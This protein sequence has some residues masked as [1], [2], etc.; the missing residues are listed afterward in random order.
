MKSWR[1]NRWRHWLGE[2]LLSRLTV[3]ILLATIVSWLVFSVVLLYEA[4]KET[5]ELLDKQLSAYTQMLWQNL[6]DE[7]DLSAAPVEKDHH[8]VRLAFTLY[9]SDGSLQASNLLPSFPRQA[10]NAPDLR[11]INL[12]GQDWRICIRQNKDRQLIVGE[13]LG[14]HRKIAN[15]M[16]EHLLETAMLALLVLLPLLL[17]A[18]HRGLKPLQI[19]DRELAKRA[20]NNLEPLDLNV[21]SEIAPLRDRLNT[22]FEQVE[23]TLAR[24]RR[25]TADAAHELRTPLAGLR[26]QLE[27]AQSS[28]RTETRQK[29]LGRAIEGVDRT[30]HLVAQLLEMS[31]LE[32]GEAPTFS[33]IHLPDLAGQALRE[34]GIAC[35][36]PRLNVSD[37]IPIVGHALLLNL[38][39]RN[40]LDNAR[41]YA[42]S[43]AVVG[44]EIKGTQ[45]TVFDHG[46]G[47]SE[48]TLA[49]MGERFFR[50]AGQSQPGAGLGL[51]IV[52]RIA[53]L[54]GAELHFANR[55]E[56]GFLVG[57]QFKA[58][59]GKVL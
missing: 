2:S 35:E 45:L 28:P 58:I 8:H 19:V 26:V 37:P 42:G 18:I 12:H 20:P 4:R 23:A 44:I 17:W 56:G 34:A 47:V 57:I 53:Q 27:L 32:H 9:H 7:D 14:N 11:V 38:L 55:P 39:L 5:T 43:E 51:S 15:E 3:L 24:E 10:S 30:T 54:H 25:F 1:I 21:P 52:R 6:G 48:E 16:A 46:P 29:A 13:P 31:R 49:R 59:E 22:L 33:A 50:P 36:A 40:L 41:R